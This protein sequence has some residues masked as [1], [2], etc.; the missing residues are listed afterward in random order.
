MIYQKRISGPMLDRIDIH[1]SSPMIRGSKCRVS[2]LKNSPATG[3]ASRR[4]LSAP[5]FK[6]PAT[7]SRCPSGAPIGAFRWDK[8]HLQCR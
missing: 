2:T 3:W 7:S 8:H 5:V 4:R 1:T 6:P